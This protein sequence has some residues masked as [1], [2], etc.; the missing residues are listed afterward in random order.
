MDPELVQ[1]L[2]LDA[3]KPAQ[4]TLVLELKH[5]ESDDVFE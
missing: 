4:T 5:C 1:I 3:L 2:D